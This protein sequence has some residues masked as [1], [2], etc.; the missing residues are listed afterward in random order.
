MV[1]DT[2]I[3]TTVPNGTTNGVLK[4]TTPGGTATSSGSFTVTT[5]PVI[6]GFTPTSGPPGTQVTISG[7]NLNN[8]SSVTIAGTA[9][10][11]NS[12]SATQILATV[13]APANSQGPIVVTT[14]GGTADT[15]SLRDA[16]LHGG[17][18]PACA[19]N[20]FVHAHQWHRRDFGD[21]QW[22]QFHRNYGGAL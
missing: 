9:A 1:S 10:V 16:Q 15:T 6:T 14:P 12:D 18:P 4:V 13:E 17:V 7:S 5:T 3:D 11:I 2:Q 8:A 22:G 20:F 21:N 19:R